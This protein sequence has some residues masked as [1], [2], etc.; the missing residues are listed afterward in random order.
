MSITIELENKKIK[1]DDS[2]V[3]LISHYK[4]LEE[5]DCEAGGILIGRENKES[6]NLIIEYATEPYGKD[7]RTRIS[8]HRRDR[9]HIEF[10]N[11]LYEKYSGIYAYV[12][13]WHTHPENY[14]SYSSTDIKNWRKISKINADKQKIY[15]HLI[16]GNKEIRV[17]EYSYNSKDAKRIY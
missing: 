13:E 16:L 8:F 4:Q 12:G 14:P 5:K 3:N 10:Y 1:I 9:K 11:T 7:K 6:G 2:V 17:W 15:Y